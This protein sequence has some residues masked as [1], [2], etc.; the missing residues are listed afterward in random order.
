MF[1]T[2]DP[3]SAPAALM[4]NLK[5]NHVLHERN[6]I[7]TVN[8]ATTPRVADEDRMAVEKIAGAFWRMRLSFGYMETPNVPKA[9]VLARRD[10]LAFEMMSTSYFLNRRSFRIT[11]HSAMPHLAE[12]PLRLDDQGRLRR[13]RLLP[14][15]VE[16]GAGARA[17][18]GGVRVGIR[19][20][21]KG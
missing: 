6:V 16:P 15:A 21:L 5:H 3:D 9:L 19:F 10:G 14:A 4:H 20:A 2:S 1:L 18:A 17:A 7:V 8:V 12:R 11:E 13:Q